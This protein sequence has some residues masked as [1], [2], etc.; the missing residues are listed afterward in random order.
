MNGAEVSWSGRSLR[1]ALALGIERGERDVPLYP[2]HV[3]PRLPSWVAVPEPVGHP[4]NTDT[5]TEVRAIAFEM[6]IL[7][8]HIH[9]NNN[10]K[11][12]Y[13]IWYKGYG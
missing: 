11:N 12:F 10:N 5:Q 1:W 2:D 8:Y 3:S 6:C 7:L 4:S 13:V 9:D